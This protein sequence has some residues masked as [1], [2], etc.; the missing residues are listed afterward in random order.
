MTAC[1]LL[2]WIALRQQWKFMVIYNWGSIVPWR[3]LE[4]SGLLHQHNLWKLGKKIAWGEGRGREGGSSRKSHNVNWQLLFTGTTRHYN[5]SREYRKCVNLTK[6][7]RRRNKTSTKTLFKCEE[8]DWKRN[9]Q[10]MRRLSKSS[11]VWV[12]WTK[13]ES[14]SNGPALSHRNWKGLGTELV[15]SQTNFFGNFARTIFS[16]SQQA[17]EK[18]EIVFVKHH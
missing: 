17:L 3:I 15:G 5:D 9:W 16:E 4:K 13:S 2:D 18:I 12:I 8:R 10:S 1:F 6:R 11:R 7:S 14:T